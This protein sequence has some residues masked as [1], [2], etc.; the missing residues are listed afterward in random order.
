MGDL[1]FFYNLLTWKY[2]KYIYEIHDLSSVINSDLF[3]YSIFL[4]RYRPDPRGCGSQEF[5]LKP[6]I[7]KDLF[8]H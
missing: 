4:L 2:Q 5:P 7:K 3:E 1:D 6:S 8:H